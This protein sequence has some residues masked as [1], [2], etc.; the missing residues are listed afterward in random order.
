MP[1]PSSTPSRAADSAGLIYRSNSLRSLELLATQDGGTTHALIA[2]LGKS[3][4]PSGRRELRDRILRP[5]LA[6]AKINFRL[7]SVQVV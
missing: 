2:A 4:T 1:P 3:R 7:G 5:L 6:V